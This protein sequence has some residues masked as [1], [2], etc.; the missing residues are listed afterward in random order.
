[1]CATLVVAK[2]NA[3]ISSTEPWSGCMPVLLIVRAALADI[4]LLPLKSEVVYISPTTCSFWAGL[5]VPIP[6][7]P[8][9]SIL[10]YSTDEPP[11]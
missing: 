5:S 7:L 4:I 3:T 10:R 11:S 1:M 8:A 9:L 6:T 2:L